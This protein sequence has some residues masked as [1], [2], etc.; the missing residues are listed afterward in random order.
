MIGTQTEIQTVLGSR[1]RELRVKRGWSQETLAEMCHLH[2]SHMGEIERGLANVT[3]ST[4]VAVAG[5]LET[6]VHAL[7]NE[8]A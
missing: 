1:I 4:L 6:S 5:K 2:R 8:I 7:L 3:L